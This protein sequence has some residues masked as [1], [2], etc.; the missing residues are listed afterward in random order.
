MY[1]ASV[2]LSPFKSILNPNPWIA[3]LQD[4]PQRTGNTPN[5]ILRPAGQSQTINDKPD[6]FKIPNPRKSHPRKK[7]GNRKIPYGLWRTSS[8]ARR[9][10]G[11][12]PSACRA[13]NSRP[14]LKTFIPTLQSHTSSIRRSTLEIC[15]NSNLFSDCEK[16]TQSNLSCTQKLHQIDF[17]A[18]RHSRQTVASR[19]LL[20]LRPLQVGKIQKKWGKKRHKSPWFG[21][22]HVARGSSG[23]KPL[24]RCAPIRACV[25]R[26]SELVSTYPE[27]L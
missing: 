8:G 17:W 7:G 13:P 9:L 18:I 12:S 10:R 24:R 2:H 16:A 5:Y 11:E 19:V 20:D 21:R 22:E 26:G 4:L 27:I 25:E 14:I 3:Y 23:L 15:P 6:N 1:I